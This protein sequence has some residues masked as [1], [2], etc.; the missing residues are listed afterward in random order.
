MEVKTKLCRPR[1]RERLYSFLRREVPEGRQGF[2]VYPLVEE[3]D[4]LDVGAAVEEHKRLS[5]EVFHDLRLAL[6]H[7]RMS[8]SEK[9][10]IMRAF[11]AND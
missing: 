9:D 3:S 5:E 8:G 11:R 6:L 2:I 4:K 10:E 7:G 1:E